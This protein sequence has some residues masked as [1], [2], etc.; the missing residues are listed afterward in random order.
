[1]AAITV[2]KNLDQLKP[3]LDKKGILEIVMRDKKKKFTEF[4]KLAL[5]NA[6]DGSAQQLLQ[7]ALNT[8]NKNNSL[9]ETSESLLQ[10]ISKLEQ[11]NLIFGALNLYATCVG[12]AIMNAKL[13]K[14]SSQLNKIMGTVKEGQDITANYEFGKVLSEHANM[15]DSRK[16]Q[17]Y[18][19]EE[20]MRRLVDSEYNVL[21]MLMDGFIKDHTTD[22]DNLIVSIYSMA[23]MLAVSLRYYDELYYLNNKE[24]IGDGDVW[25]SSHDNWTGIFQKL[26]SDAFVEKIQDHGVFDLGLSLSEADVYYQNLIGQ[27]KD[28]EETVAD[29]QQLILELGDSELMSALEEYI[30]QDVSNSIREAFEQTE[31]A[32][33][34]AT[35]VEVYQNAM[36]H[37]AWA[38]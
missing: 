7:N 36:K 13:D 14:M 3:F 25:H 32:M 23:S 28:M 24:V 35:V 38:A 33:K 27:V 6:P 22:I 19:T 26:R 20:Q 16:T 2:I 34:N 18:Y 29:N 30:N 5:N 9:P 21:K 10:N 11:L 12:F 17:K 15:L 8:M 4:K 37:M 31:G 1:M